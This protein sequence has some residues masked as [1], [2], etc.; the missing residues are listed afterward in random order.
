MTRDA[1]SGWIEENVHHFPL[2]IYYQDT[3]VSGI[4]YHAQY[5]HFFERARTEYLRCIGISQKTLDRSDPEAYAAFAV[6]DLS[7]SFN[8]PAHLDD[9]LTI[10]TTLR[11]LSG[12][13]CTLSQEVWRGG[14]LLVTGRLRLVFLSVDLRPKRVPVHMRR[15]FRD[16]LVK[17]DTQT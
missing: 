13:S 16:T 1:Q 9:D 14:D 15:L 12:A 5:L 3:D 4:V 2:R 8:A 11:Q 17:D 10:R 6:R 7:L